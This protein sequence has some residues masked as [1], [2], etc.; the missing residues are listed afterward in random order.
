MI[1]LVGGD[2]SKLQDLIVH[3]M[4]TTRGWISAWD[5]DREFVVQDEET[6]ADGE[7]DDDA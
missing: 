7:D 1:A 3:W 6:S 4:K 5:S 2:E